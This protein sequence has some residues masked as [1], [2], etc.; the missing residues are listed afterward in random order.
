MV[1]WC[2]SAADDTDDTGNGAGCGTIGADSET[3]AFVQATPKPADRTCDLSSL[4]Q[5]WRFLFGAGS[6][7][8]Q[9]V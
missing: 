8:S 3:M 7:A 9:V 6:V 5:Q 4:V 1:L 2:C